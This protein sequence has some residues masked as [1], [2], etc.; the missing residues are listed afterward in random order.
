[1]GLEIIEKISHKYGGD[2]RYVLAGGGNTS[3]K[4]EEFLYVKG[5]GAS[6]A[7]I[8]DTDFVKMSRAG[9]S[10][11]FKKT[12]PQEQQRR[13]AEVLLDMMNARCVG[14][15]NKRPSVE[16]LLHNLFSQKYVL[17]VHPALVNGLTCSKDGKTA[18]ERL[19]P[20]AIWI[21]ET[22]PGYTLAVK[23][24]ERIG[25]YEERNGKKAYLLFLQNHGVFFAAESKVELDALVSAV[26]G[27]I[28]KEIN[29]VPDLTALTP[30]HEAVNKIA[31]VLR[32][33][34]DKNGEAIV[35]FS[36]NGE[37]KHL[38]G[39]REAF[40]I[41][42]QPLSPD[43]MVYCESVPMFVEDYSADGL[44]TQLAEFER[45]NKF[46]PKVIF[47]KN[48]GM[49]AVGKN[50]KD[51]QTVTDVW[52][53]AIKIA[54]YARSF[55]GVR[56]MSPKTVDFISNWEAES[57]RSNVALNCNA[58]KFAG[59]IAVVTG[60]AKGLGREIAFSL[61]KEGAVVVVADMDIESGE[62]TASQIVELYGNSASVF[63]Y[64]DVADE[65]SVEMLISNTVCLYG[66]LD[67]FVNNA[68]IIKA[69]AIEET[70]L[71]DFESIL[72]V[73][74]TAYFIC[75]Q[76]AIA[77]MK[78]QREVNPEYICDIIEI[79]SKSGIAGSAMNFAY[80]GS[81]FGGIGLTQ[82][83]A[84]ELAPFGIKVNA[85]CPGNL[86]DGDLWS[87]PINGLFVQYLNAGKVPGAKTVDDVRKFYEKKVPLARGC[88]ARDVAL[89]VIYAIEQKYETGQV[90]PVTGGQIMLK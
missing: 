43:H 16:T 32:I 34:Y 73:N 50:F 82:S 47:V 2:S 68:G 46:L 67:I 51:A 6:L 77:V 9:L 3:Y 70:A 60:G 28:E 36:L 4:D 39:S 80:S 83:F 17:H 89:A 12:Y 71:N 87:N 5:S 33:L 69:G 55:G 81:K 88:E 8:K 27:K 7:T 52:L 40:E 38:S 64:T 31:P 59:K 79:N 45:V 66:G 10:E 21:E 22:E 29:E 63:I 57:Y 53:D 85:V 84:L 74:Y 37:I 78:L 35:R 30:N 18:I 24:R 23:C 90:L 25:D 62:K 75:V 72:K 65:K 41:L 76:K 44:R 56:H 86:L 1:M 54:V 11:I 13:E 58:K 26:M 49:F 20:H 42:R 15:E 61:A 48:V 19:F 14:E